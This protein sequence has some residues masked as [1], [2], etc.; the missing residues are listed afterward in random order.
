[1]LPAR[2][3]AEQEPVYVTSGGPGLLLRCR[4]VRTK[5]TKLTKS[6]CERDSGRDGTIFRS[7]RPRISE[8]PAWSSGVCVIMARLGLMSG[9]VVFP[10][11]SKMLNQEDA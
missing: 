8:R 2:V 3:V 11:L 4:N 10:K 6:G 9:G 7:T 1:V 5:L